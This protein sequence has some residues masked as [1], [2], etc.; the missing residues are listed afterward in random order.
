MYNI[1]QRYSREKASSKSIIKVTVLI[2]ISDKWKTQGLCQF[3]HYE[4]FIYPSTA[5]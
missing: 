3:S 5:A 4:K 1:A 2:A